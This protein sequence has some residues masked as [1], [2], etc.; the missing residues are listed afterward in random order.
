M[1]NRKLNQQKMSFQ[2][3]VR[4]IF[5][6]KYHKCEDAVLCILV[7]YVIRKFMMYRTSPL[8]SSFT[9][10]DNLHNYSSELSTVGQLLSLAS[11]WCYCKDRYELAYLFICISVL[12]SNQQNLKISQLY[13]SLY[14]K[15]RVIDYLKSKIRD[16]EKYNPDIKKENV[17]K[18]LDKIDECK[19]QLTDGYYLEIMNILK[20]LY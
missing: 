1:S 14:D 16:I 7:A 12:I 19:E 15:E 18:L 13:I 20:E 3:I 2:E 8:S 17:R 10:N 11:G 4:Q 5:E 9:T 6:P